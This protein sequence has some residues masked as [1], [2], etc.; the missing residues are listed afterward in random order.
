MPEKIKTYIDINLLDEL[1]YFQKKYSLELKILADHK[2][3][4]PEYKIEL[5]NKS[6]KIINT[7]ENIYS[8]EGLNKKKNKNKKLKKKKKK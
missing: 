1:K 4:I 7:V 3:V 2:F 6:K 8:I 5:L